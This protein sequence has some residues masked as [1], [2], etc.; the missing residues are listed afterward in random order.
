M[1]EF[2][3]KARKEYQCNHCGGVINIGEIYSLGRDRY[4]RYNEH[5]EQIGIKYALWKICCKCLD[6]FEK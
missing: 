3:H 2:R 5:R 6:K 4:P 1:D